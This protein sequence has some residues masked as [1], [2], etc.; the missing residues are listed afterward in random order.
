MKFDTEIHRRIKTD[1]S[2]Y[3]EY[4]PN[5]QYWADIFEEDPDF[6]EEFKMVFNNADIP[7]ANCFTP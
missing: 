2:G 6:S 4:K 1:N 5:P 7:E 3:K